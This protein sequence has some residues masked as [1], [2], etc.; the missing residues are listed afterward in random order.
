MK[1][2]QGSTETPE[3]ARRC[4]SLGTENE[5]SEE[6]LM[7][8]TGTLVSSAEGMVREWHA[9]GSPDSKEPRDEQANE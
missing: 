3:R 1:R 8:I 4:S 2:V 9:A 6:K 5:H 7:L